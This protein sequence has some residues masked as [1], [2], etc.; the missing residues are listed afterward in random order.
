MSILDPR[1]LLAALLALAITSGLS[2]WKGMTHGEQ[3]QQARMA[4]AI[5][6]ANEQAQ[7]ANERAQARVDEA[8]RIAASRERAL[9]LDAARARDAASGLR[10]SLDA[11]ERISQDSLSASNK[12]LRVTSELLATCGK[13]YGELA[14]EADRA[15]A[16]ARE[17]R[18]A[19]PR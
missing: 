13:R 3:I 19:W 17:L 10:E 2:F 9:R 7:K 5:S 15:D 18:S 6:E 16:E 14:E 11:I 4:R 1:L 8:Q 12:A